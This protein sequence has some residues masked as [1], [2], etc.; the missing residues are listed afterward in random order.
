MSIRNVR[1]LEHPGVRVL[2]ERFAAASGRKRKTAGV[3]LSRVIAPGA[4]MG[5]YSQEELAG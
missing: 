4:T 3:Q 1:M 2:A 5:L